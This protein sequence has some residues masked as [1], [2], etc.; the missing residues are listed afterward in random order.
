MANIVWR[1]SA[2]TN[3]FGLRSFW[4]YDKETGDCHSFL[5]SRIYAK[6]QALTG[7][8]LKGVE[9][10]QHELTVPKGKRTK[11]EKEFINNL[12]VPRHSPER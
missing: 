2:N 4:V 6:G 7:S 3:A 1:I 10:W 12:A 5:T 8:E 11:F 9:L